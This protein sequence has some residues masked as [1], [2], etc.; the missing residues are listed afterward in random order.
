M[1][2]HVIYL[3]TCIVAVLIRVHVNGVL[4]NRVFVVVLFELS[5]DM[6]A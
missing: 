4:I 2:E 5:I 3:V 1:H 6:V